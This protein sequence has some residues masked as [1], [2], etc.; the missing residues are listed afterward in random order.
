M[1]SIDTVTKKA[2]EHKL[3]KGE[4]KPNLVNLKAVALDGM[5]KTQGK[6]NSSSDTL[7]IET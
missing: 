7:V 5:F 3:S 4:G 2:V 6:L 1:L